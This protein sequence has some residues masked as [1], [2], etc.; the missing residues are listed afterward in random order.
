MIGPEVAEVAVLYSTVHSRLS[1]ELLILLQLAE[2][3][4]VQVAEAVIVLVTMALTAYFRQLLLPVAV[5][6][7]D[8][9]L[10]HKVIVIHT[11]AV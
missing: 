10:L 1:L 5:L 4:L 8:G 9:L 3:A 6:V 7:A 11:A 2:V